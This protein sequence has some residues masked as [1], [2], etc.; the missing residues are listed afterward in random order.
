MRF[1]TFGQEVQLN[2]LLA[3]G[4]RQHR[5]P[6]RGCALTHRW[7]ALECL[8]EGNTSQAGGLAGIDA[9]AFGGIDHQSPG[10]ALDHLGRRCGN[11]NGKLHRLAPWRPQFP[12]AE[13]LS[14]LHDHRDPSEGFPRKV[15][16]QTGLILALP[17]IRIDQHGRGLGDFFPHDFPHFVVGGHVEL[18]AEHAGLLDR[19]ER[20]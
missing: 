2:R 8:A 3:E 1:A 20:R 9:K 14:Q 19:V 12:L 4:E 5:P 6:L 10:G 16:D 17:M 7:D 18:Q 11:V 15:H 13:S